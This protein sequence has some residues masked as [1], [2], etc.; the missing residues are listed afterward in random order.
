[1]PDNPIKGKAGNITRCRQMLSYFQGRSSRIEVDFVSEESWGRWDTESQ[2]R[3]REQYPAINLHVIDRKVSRENFLSYLFNYK[4][5]YFV[6][7]LFR[8]SAFDFTTPLLKR[9]MRK[10]LARH[11]YD[12]VVISYVH[13]GS[14]VDLIPYPTHKVVDTHDFITAQHKLSKRLRS[15]QIGAVFSQE[16]RVLQKFDEIWTYSIEEKYIF[17]QFV[18]RLVKLIPVTFPINDIRSAK[19]D[20][21]YDLLYVASD[22]PHNIKGIGW[23]Y[24]NVLPLLDKYI[25]VA[26]VG[27]IAKHLPDHEQVFKLGVLDSLAD[28][29]RSTRVVICPLLSGTGVKIKVLEGLSYGK[30][31]VT[32]VRGVDGL[33]NKR[34]NGCIVSNNPREF[35][36]AVHL[37]LDDEEYYQQ[38]AQEGNAYL[39][40][41]HRQ[42]D[43]IRVLDEVFE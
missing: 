6:S 42:I 9:K 18:D 20:K 5:P 16:L 11:Q 4:I 36:N 34:Q 37:L 26:V 38:I 40:N 33:L 1:M 14:L 30:P 27:N 12:V 29:Y 17:E 31:V 19:P 23:F 28:A 21:V 13:W 43:E 25:K 15:K 39:E 24:E 8:S 35:A 7:R 32:T 3:F 2:A 41:N 22:N 10:M